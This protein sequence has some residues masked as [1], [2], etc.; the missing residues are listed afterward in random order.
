MDSIINNFREL[1]DR[2]DVTEPEIQTFMEKHS[3]IIPVP[4]LLGHDLLWN[5]V[6]SKFVLDRDKIPDFA[7]L[8][9]NSAHWR[10]VLIEL[11]RPQKR[12]FVENPY[13]D[14]HSN[15]RSAIAKSRTG[16]RSLNTG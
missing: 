13:V 14:F 3:E 2:D 15:T 11:E 12:L 6:I 7:F 4:Y 5:A 8:T 9:K 1:I 16:N 10:L